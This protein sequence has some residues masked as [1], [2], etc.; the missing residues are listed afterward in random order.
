MGELKNIKKEEKHNVIFKQNLV[1]IIK[2]C[3]IFV[4]KFF[5]LL[6]FIFFFIIVISY[7]TNSVLVDY[8]YCY[9]IWELYHIALPFIETFFLSIKNKKFI[10]LILKKYN[11]IFNFWYTYFIKFN[12][13]WK[14]YY[15]V[16]YSIGY[17]L[18]NIFQLF[19]ISLDYFF[20]RGCVFI[21]LVL[22]YII[23]TKISLYLALRDDIHYAL[24][25]FFIGCGQVLMVVF[26][27]TML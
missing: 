23:F 24:V 21:S 1:K 17:Y 25:L 13:R 8:P 22:L 15:Y 6:I 3:L 5:F 27:F 4:I 12:L 26:V 19:W 9:Y 14:Y 11:F 10:N 20:F 2:L 7:Y 18:W 16:V